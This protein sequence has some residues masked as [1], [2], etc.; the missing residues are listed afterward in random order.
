MHEL[1]IALQL[2]LAVLSDVQRG[3]PDEKAVVQRR[4]RLALLNLDV[5]PFEMADA[6]EGVLVDRCQWIAGERQ[7]AQRWHVLERVLVDG[8]DQIRGEID[9]IDAL[10]SESVDRSQ[11][12]VG[13]VDVLQL[14]EVL[15][16]GEQRLTVE[17][18]GQV[19]KNESFERREIFNRNQT[20][21]PCVDQF[22]VG[23][24]LTWRAE[25]VMSVI[26]E[27]DIDQ[28]QT[29]ELRQLLKK[30]LEIAFLIVRVR[31]MVVNILQRQGFQRL[32]RVGLKDVLEVARR[33]GQRVDRGILDEE[34]LEMIDLC[35][36]LLVETDEIAMTQAQRV[37]VEVSKCFITDV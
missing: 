15:D 34:L 37:D 4:D 32:E 21:L 6:A 30:L 25:I 5:E 8:F 27:I 14:G 31:L 10:R 11:S 28:F 1:A 33:R 17:Y 16:R 29:V 7:R 36:R 13:E 35:E 12:I 22:Q 3:M 9:L 2:R 23:Q 26:I 24:R 18:V 20:R 19:E